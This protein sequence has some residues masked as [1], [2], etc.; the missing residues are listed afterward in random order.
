MK[1]GC[2]WIDLSEALNSRQ[3]VRTVIAN[4]ADLTARG[5]CYTRS[6]STALLFTIGILSTCAR[7]TQ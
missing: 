6:A 2:V 5:F 4:P 7:A 3:N 1:G